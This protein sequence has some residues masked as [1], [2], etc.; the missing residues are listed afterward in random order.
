[1]QPAPARMPP[2]DNGDEQAGDTH[3]TLWETNTHLH[4]PQ[5]LSWKEG[6]KEGGWVGVQD[7]RS[8]IDA[9]RRTSRNE[10]FKQASRGQGGFQEVGCNWVQRGLGDEESGGVVARV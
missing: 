8:S 1:M 10:P 5:S 6:R 7:T 4:F 3:S 2:Q 9:R